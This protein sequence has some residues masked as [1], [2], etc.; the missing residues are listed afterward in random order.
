MTE[1]EDQMEISFSRPDS[2]KNLNPESPT[3]HLNVPEGYIQK[4][5]SGILNCQKSLKIET[6][7]SSMIIALFKIGQN[8]ESHIGDFKDQLKN[9][10]KNM[11][12]PS[13][14]HSVSL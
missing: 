7:N 3:E 6:G 1:S 5:K 4:S 8:N 12:V 2:S 13:S 9:D 10:L 14:T 11:M